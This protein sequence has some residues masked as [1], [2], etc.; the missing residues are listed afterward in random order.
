MFH[1]DTCHREVYQ[2]NIRDK[3]L[4]REACFHLG[5]VKLEMKRRMKT[6]SWR[7]HL[8]LNA[9]QCFTGTHA[10]VR[11]TKETFVT[12]RLPRGA[13][14]HKDDVKVERHCDLE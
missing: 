10:T 5:D 2:R 9:A 1:S 4:P 13:C 11:F 3:Q 7:K 8:I 14:F 12:K 6:L